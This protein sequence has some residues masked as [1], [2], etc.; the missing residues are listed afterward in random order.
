MTLARSRAAVF[1][2]G[3]EAGE[4]VVFVS[5]QQDPAVLADGVGDL[6]V[7]GLLQ[8]PPACP[9]AGS[10]LS[11]PSWLRAMMQLVWVGEVHL[12]ERRQ[13]ELRVVGVEVGVDVRVRGTRR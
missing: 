4:G 11:L 9:V 5:I 2:A 10:G 8:A 13:A 6:D 1:T 7:Q 12:R 3:R